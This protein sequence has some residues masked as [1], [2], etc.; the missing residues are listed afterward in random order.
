MT[1]I[2]CVSMMNDTYQEFQNMLNSQGEV[3]TKS[4]K[5]VNPKTLIPFYESFGMPFYQCFW[6]GWHPE[7]EMGN[8]YYSGESN[9]ISD[10]ALT[11]EGSMEQMT[12]PTFSE[13]LLFYL[14]QFEF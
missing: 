3:R 9:T 5:V 13:W 11:D 8:V 10:P 1:G 4:G 7:Q 12:F 14:E 6:D 2:T